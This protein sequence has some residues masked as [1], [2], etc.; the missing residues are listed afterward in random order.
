MRKV[1]LSSAIRDRLDELESFL[2]WELKLS[3][4]AADKRMDRIGIRLGTLGTNADYALC[5][6]KR[7][8]ALGYRCVSFEGWVFAY[9]VF[10]EGVI[11]RNMAHGKLLDDTEK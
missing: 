5:R 4:S 8:R 7:W 2:R 3:K 6:F 9:E 10:D 11:I 1:V